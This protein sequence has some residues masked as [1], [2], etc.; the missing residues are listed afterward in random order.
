MV[1]SPALFHSDRLFTYRDIMA[2]LLPSLHFWHKTV[3]TDWQLPVWNPFFNCGMPAWADLKALAVYPLNFLLL[4]FP[5]DKTYFGF[6]WFVF[7]HFV[8]MFAGMRLFLAAILQ[9]KTIATCFA[10]VYCLS[11]YA[12]SAISMVNQLVGMTVLPYFAYYAHRFS[13]TTPPRQGF[14]RNVFFLSICL[15]LPVYGAAIE[16]SYFFALALVAIT[17][18]RFSVLFLRCLAVV[19]AGSILLAA[20]QLVPAF[21]LLG[22]SGR[23]VG[24]LPLNLVVTNSF[25]YFRFIEYFLPLPFGNHWPESNFWAFRY[26]NPASAGSP[27]FFT[28]YLGASFLT[29]FLA[30]LMFFARR[31]WILLLALLLLVCLMMGAFFS[32]TFYGVFYNYF[33]LWKIFKYPEKLGVFVSFIL[34]SMQAIGWQKIDQARMRD[35]LVATASALVVIAAA[36]LV[37]RS[38][39]DIE[40]ARVEPDR[41]FHALLFSLLLPLPLLL[42]RRFNQLQQYRWLVFSLILMTDLFLFSRSMLWLQP[43]SVFERGEIAAKIQQDMQKRNEQ[44]QAGA[45]FYYT[46]LLSK[47]RDMSIP[48]GGMDGLDSVGR[49]AARMHMRLALGNSIFYDIASTSA[50]GG[51]IDLQEKTDF[52]RS[53]ANENPTRYLNLLGVYYYSTFAG[54]DTSRLQLLANLDAINFLHSPRTIEFMPGHSSAVKRIIHDADF[55]PKNSMII[56]KPSLIKTGFR[57]MAGATVNNDS[58]RFSRF[59]RRTSKLSFIVHSFEAAE[60][61]ANEAP[62]YAYVLVN[63]SYDRYWRAFVDGQPAEI[64][65]ANAWA[66]AVAVNQKCSRGCEI[67]MRYRNPLITVGLLISTIFLITCLLVLYF[68]SGNH[69]ARNQR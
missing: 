19:G 28:T 32:A 58:F 67:T 7:V 21:D 34:V 3:L 51:R 10:L 31:H 16:Y 11:G 60:D 40:A 42:A 56:E 43:D 45:P 20:A 55:Q 36:L 68:Q 30:Y 4:L 13:T 35:G 59:K 12:M 54:D 6:S 53:L 26:A 24:K 64:L 46:A 18:R 44:L 9:N 62:R 48:T 41:F 14:N 63:Q 37:T 22:Q 29:G 25:H 65:R 61:S 38:F 69:L 17:A 2:G 49:L 27:L 52:F 1:F 57:P 66:T 8:L 50:Q 5:A 23:A 47:P 33:P 39:I 15:A